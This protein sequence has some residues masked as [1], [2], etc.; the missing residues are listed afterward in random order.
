MSL[1]AAA[2]GTM[3]GQR[4][5]VGKQLTEIAQEINNENG[6]SL[7]LLNS[8]AWKFKSA[9]G[10]ENCRDRR[11]SSEKTDIQRKRSRAE[12]KQRGGLSDS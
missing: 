11:R 9:I 12:S 6:A 4:A 3:A 1:L 7:D 8:F 2:D 5:H 10:G